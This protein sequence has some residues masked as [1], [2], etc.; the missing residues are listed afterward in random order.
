MYLV[1]HQEVVYF[2]RNAWYWRLSLVVWYQICLHF[3]YDVYHCITLS[4]GPLIYLLDR[5][6]R[7]LEAKPVVIPNFVTFL[8]WGGR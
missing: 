1:S 6:L 4:V 3:P 5:L 2:F 7:T 8:R